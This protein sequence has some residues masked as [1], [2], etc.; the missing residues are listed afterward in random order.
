[1]RQP[2]EA[3]RRNLA[4]AAVTLLA[5][6]VVGLQ[7]SSARAV[8]NCTPASAWGS[9]RADL[10]AQVVSLINQRRVGQGL[11]QLTISAPL[12]ASS[13]WKSLHM[14][15]NGYFGHDD[16][17]PP[18][19]RTAY[20]RAK[21]CGY[22]SGAWGENIAAGYATAQSVVNGWLASPGH[23][24]NIENAGFTTTGVGVAAR[25]GGQL[26]WTQSF[27]TGTGGTAPSTPAPP[28]PPAPVSTAPPATSPKSAAAATAT[29]VTT[30]RG[31]GAKPARVT[32][33]ASRSRIAASVPFVL[34][35]SGRP[36][37]AGSVRCRAEVEGR[38]LR[39]LANVFAAEAAH[40]AW[41]V[42]SW[43][44]GKR[45]TGVVAVQIGDTAAT[46]LFIRK[47]G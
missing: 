38:R 19:A 11:S 13:E 9:N 43:A 3:V 7:A 42:P 47:L 40:C 27:G 18:V 25:N 1:M 24:A 23:K 16:P 29:T 44:R 45:L 31:V 8:T 6:A 15:G 41:R 34:I 2:F 26:Y 5:V 21:D 36:V 14:A 22:G 35:A 4:F 46:R 30:A 10:A 28:A 32:R 12:T 39:V 20:Q 33:S 37:T 17:A